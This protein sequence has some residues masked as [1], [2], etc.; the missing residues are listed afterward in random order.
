MFR[1]DVF[2][3]I[4]KYIERYFTHPRIRQ[5]L[6]FPVLF[7]GALPENTPAL[8]SLM[9]YA[10]IKGGTWY[11][12]GGMYSVVSAMHKLAV[13]NGVE[14]IFNE[15]VS[16]ITVQSDAVKKVIARNN[17]YEAD[18]VIGGADYH[19]IEQHLL[20]NGFQSYDSNYWDRR[21]VAPSCLLYF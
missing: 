11:P 8:Y 14:F 10:D 13:E 19:H 1:L 5:M 16:G 2:T 7:L 17:V 15:N 21:V 18:V 6:E 4:K 9:N 12:M 3:S 20:P